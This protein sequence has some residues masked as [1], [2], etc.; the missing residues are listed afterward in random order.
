MH[1]LPPNLIRVRYYGILT[2]QSRNANLDRCR[3]LLGVSDPIDDGNTDS[4]PDRLELHGDEAD[5]MPAPSCPKCGT[6]D[7]EWQYEIPPKVE[8][9]LHRYGP[10][11]TRSKWMGV[12]DPFATSHPP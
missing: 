3:E 2:N 11:A 9:V 5:N 10:V 6:P 7:M 8:W 4:P 12:G 1:I